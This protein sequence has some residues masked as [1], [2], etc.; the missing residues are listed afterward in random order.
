MPNSNIFASFILI[1]LFCL[2]IYMAF[3]LAFIE[4]FI[5]LT[6]PFTGHNL[7][8]SH[9]SGLSDLSLLSHHNSPSLH[10]NYSHP[11]VYLSNCQSNNCITLSIT[12]FNSSARPAIIS[13]YRRVTACNLFISIWVLVYTES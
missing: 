1:K 3:T 6:S 7:G 2:V 13:P 9:I 12:N 10:T 4:L 8:A 5:I 11:I